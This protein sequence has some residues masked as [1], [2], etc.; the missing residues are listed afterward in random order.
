MYFPSCVT[1][2]SVSLIS[3]SLE[4][5]ASWQ[6]V[7]QGGHDEEKFH[8]QVQRVQ[9]AQQNVHFCGVFEALLKVQL[10]CHLD[11][12]RVTRYYFKNYPGHFWGT[13]IWM[14]LIFVPH[15]F[16]SWSALCV[17]KK[18]QERLR[19]ADIIVFMEL[20]VRRPADHSMLHGQ[21]LSS[22]GEDRSLGLWKTAHLM[23]LPQ[24][25]QAGVKPSAWAGLDHFYG[26]SLPGG[27]SCL[28]PETFKK[29]SLSKAHQ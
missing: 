5:K 4:G 27:P 1:G 10:I 3:A 14:S 22:G 9:L 2:R 25:M 24:K 26:F 8:L 16:M 17:H 18:A 23:E 20:R 19:R 11:L 6:F 28:V 12:S 15:K 29:K 7:V 21:S 13:V